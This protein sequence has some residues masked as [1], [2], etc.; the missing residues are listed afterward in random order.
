M[1]KNYKETLTHITTFIF[2]VDGVF[3]DNTVYLTPDGEQIRTA[4]VR[5]GYAVQLA[6]KSG[7]RIC[8]ITGGRSEGVR[9]RFEGLGVTEIHMGASNKLEI[10]QSLLAKH[11]LTPHEICYMGDDIPDHRVMQRVAL[12]CCP[13]DAAPEI[14]A[15]SRYISHLNG[16]H[17]C[18][19]D[20]LEQ[21]M[22]LHGKWFTDQAHHW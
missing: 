17:G 21:T 22:R 3:T 5:D 4:N 20:I 8:I 15:I 10:F 18:V 16:G 2:D 19:R 14:R 11:N 6:V 13:A 1:S 12:P 7:Y 9:K